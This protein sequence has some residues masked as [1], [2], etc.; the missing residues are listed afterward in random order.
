MISLEFGTCLILL[1]DLLTLI[2]RYVFLKEEE[3]EEEEGITSWWTL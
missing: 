1:N 2:D 3:E